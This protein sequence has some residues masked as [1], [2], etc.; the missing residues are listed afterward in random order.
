[1]FEVLKLLVLHKQERVY[2]LSSVLDFGCIG[3]TGM[4]NSPLPEE[5]G[6]S[7]IK[8][9]FVKGIIFFDTADLYG[10]HTNKVLVGKVSISVS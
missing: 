4:S 5:E 6:I 2:Q 9:T 1:M 8:D 7:I 10:A 3:L